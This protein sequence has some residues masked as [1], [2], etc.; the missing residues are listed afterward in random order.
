MRVAVLLAA[1]AALWV[2]PARAADVIGPQT[3]VQTDTLT[4]DQGFAYFD[5]S[6]GPL[7][8]VN[9]GI[10]PDFTRQFQAIYPG[11][12]DTELISWDASIDQ[13]CARGSC[14]SLAAKGQANLDLTYDAGVGSYAYFAVGLTG[15]PMSFDLDPASYNNPPF[16]NA[17]FWL[18]NAGP[19]FYDQ[20]LTNIFQISDGGTVRNTTRFLCGGLNDGCD[21][22][23]FTLTYT[24][25]PGGV[26]E[27]STWAMMLLGFGFI[28]S[29][30]RRITRYGRSEPCAA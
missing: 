1:V 20:S 26:P 18:T 24:Y 19:G 12:L 15:A 22:S 9:L 2:Q 13:F 25:A 14:S 21:N 28:G 23:V 16:P 29:A 6:L 30:M 8:S 11:H 10:K 7:L 4:R 17:R 27:P 5:Q 3:I